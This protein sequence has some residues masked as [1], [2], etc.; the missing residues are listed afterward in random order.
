V[1]LFWPLGSVAAVGFG[2]YA[3]VQ[4][5]HAMRIQRVIMDT[6]TAKLRSLA[7]GLVEVEGRVQ[8]RSRVTAPFTTRPCA[9]WQVELQTL[10][11]SNKGLKEWHTVYK[12]QSGNPFYLEDGTG[13]AMLYPQ[14][15]DIRAGDLVQ[16]ETHGLGVPEPY[17][18]FMADRQ[19]GMRHV[20]SM[21][22]MRFRERIVD[23]GRAVFVLGRA[24]PKPHA[25][26]VSMDDEALQA[27]GTDAVGATHVRTLD[28]ACCAVIR[29]GKDDPAFIISERSEK[30]MTME[31]GFK[32]FGG[33]VGGP[34]L[35]LFGLWCLIELAKSGSLPLPH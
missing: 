31:Y 28:G 27:T 24:T 25:V 23:E 26:D 8:A 16:E 35:A 3:F 11:Q 32:A 15:A 7:M 9:W 29:R 19:L 22:A 30:T 21:G 14:G 13:T 18:S 10:S 6:P 17:A 33:L 4:G 5:F 12:E 34:A 2:T 20:W 1:S